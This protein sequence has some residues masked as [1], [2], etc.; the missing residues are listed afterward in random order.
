MYLFNAGVWR[1]HPQIVLTLAT[2]HETRAFV[3]FLNI[4]FLFDSSCTRNTIQTNPTTSPPT[5][6]PVCV[7]NWQDGGRFSLNNYGFVPDK[8]SFFA[9]KRFEV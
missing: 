2:G 1:A 4:E 6:L 5:V 9:R 8:M 3:S 7:V